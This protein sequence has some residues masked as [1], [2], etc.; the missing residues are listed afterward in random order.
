[1][2]AFTKYYK[3]PPASSS[4]QIKSSGKSMSS[5]PRQATNYIW[6][7]INYNA[8]NNIELYHAFINMDKNAS[9]MT[10]QTIYNLLLIIYKYFK[11]LSNYRMN[12]NNHCF[13]LLLFINLFIIMRI[14]TLEIFVSGILLHWPIKSL[15]SN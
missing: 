14:A 8:H 13:F 1:M 6:K 4:S 15:L 2:D 12:M 9:N 10:I 7:Q 5:S 3:T 11:A